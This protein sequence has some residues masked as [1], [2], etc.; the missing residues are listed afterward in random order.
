MMFQFRSLFAY[1][2]PFSIVW[3][4]PHLVVA[5]RGDMGPFPP[6]RGSLPSAPSLRRKNKQNQL[7]SANLWI[8]DP[9]NRILPSRCPATRKI[10]SGAA[11]GHTIW[12]INRIL[13]VFLVVVVLY[14]LSWKG[15]CSLIN[16]FF[17]L[18]R[19]W[20]VSSYSFLSILSR[21]VM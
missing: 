1:P 7:H 3:L 2:F 12:W 4:L 5:S 15:F 9:Q 11:T 20:A 13:N 6:V 10:K 19:Q 17:P 8:F 16:L 21:L 14:L 18:F